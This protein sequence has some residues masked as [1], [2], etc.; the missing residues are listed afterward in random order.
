VNLGDLLQAPGQLAS[1]RFFRVAYLPTCACVVYLLVLI[2]AGAPSHRVHFG[3]AWRTAAH[4]G[5]GEIVLLAIAIT[6]IAV[7]VQPFQLSLVRVLEGDFP[8]ADAARK[9]QVSRKARLARKRD[10]AIAK[11]AKAAKAAGSAES[12]DSPT[13]RHALI[14]DAGVASEQLRLRFP[15]PDQLV[16]ATGLGNALAAVEDTTGAAYGLDAVVTWPRLYPLLSDQVRAAVDDSRDGLDA[17]ARFAATG[18]V[19]AVATILL[20]APHSGWWTLLGLVPLG[21]AVVSYLAAITAAIGYG[22]AMQVAFDL[23][24]FDLLRALRLVQP[25][26][27]SGDEGEMVSNLRLSDFLR[28]GVPVPFDYV[29]VADPGGKAANG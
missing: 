21:V 8:G 25:E 27:Q 7:V 10:D 16:R 14:Q 15:V 4:L 19:A 5:I 6:L 12:T 26:R 29:P 11:A 18:A 17:A 3:R 2:W 20:L 24:R 13:T 9:F 1:S 28:Q 23:H 22:L